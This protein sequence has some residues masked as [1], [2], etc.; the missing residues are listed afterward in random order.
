[1]NNCIITIC[2]Y[3]STDGEIEKSELTTT[4]EVSGAAED[5]SILYS[6]QSD[7]LKGC[8]TTLHV[9]DGSCVDISR[10][11]KYTTQ[12]KIE[13]GKRNICCYTTPMGPISM[14]VYTSR[15]KSD[16]S[17]SDKIKLDFS[18]TLDFNNSFISKNRL[19][20]TAEYKEVR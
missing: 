7:E 9:T 19:K 8:M 1:M 18:Y 14:G 16:F 2:D 11:G 15:V 5:Y 4:A 13:Q 20:I 17:E 6:E 10:S 3:H 12:M